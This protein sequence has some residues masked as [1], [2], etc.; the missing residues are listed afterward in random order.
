MIMKST[1]AS[2]RAR[3]TLEALQWAVDKALE[4]KLR[5]GEYAVIWH[6]D[7]PAL[8]AGEGATEARSIAD[9]TGLP[10]LQPNSSNV[11][12][13]LAAAVSELKG[14]YQVRDE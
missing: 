12:E 3:D 7:A 1:T 6:R 11:D 2:D 8:L 14:A 10:V 4:R 9:I 5:L 13:R